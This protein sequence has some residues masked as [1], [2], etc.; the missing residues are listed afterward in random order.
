[1]LRALTLG[2]WLERGA[3]RA[4]DDVPDDPVPARL[5]FLSPFDRLIHDRARARALFDFEYRL[6]MYVPKARRKY[7]YYVLPVLRGDRIAGRIDIARQKPSNRLRVNGVWWEKGAKPVSLTRAL[8]RLEAEV[9][10]GLS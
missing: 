7:G 9:S 4:N 10:S 5:T 2:V 1:V 3:L 8:R 6:E